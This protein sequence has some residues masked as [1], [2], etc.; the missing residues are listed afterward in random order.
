MSAYSLI[1]SSVNRK[2]NIHPETASHFCVAHC[3]EHDLR[4]AWK[5]AGRSAC[6]NSRLL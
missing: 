1:L 4:P 2:F 5:P 6:F 3:C